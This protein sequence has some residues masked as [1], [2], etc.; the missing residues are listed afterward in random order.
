MPGRA[1][2]SRAPLRPPLARRRA[3]FGGCSRRV[4]SPHPPARPCSCATWRGWLARASC[5]S[6]LVR[7]AGALKELGA[8]DAVVCL[9]DLKIG[10]RSLA[11]TVRQTV[12]G[13]RDAFYR[14]D[15]LKTQKKA[16]APALAS[17]TIALAGGALAEA[18]RAMEEA[19]AT[20]D[21]AALARTL[22]NLPPNLCTPTRLAEEAK[23][24]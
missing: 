7:A 9:A 3:H 5:L 22:G 13:I 12:L 21:G 17:V 10:E 20:A 11:W 15:E 14:F 8:K 24:L 18:Q 2:V 19:V 4:T 16:P 23:K 1:E 6:V